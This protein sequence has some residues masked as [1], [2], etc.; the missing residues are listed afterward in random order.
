[1]EITALIITIVWIIWGTAKMKWHPFVV[2]LIAAFGLALALGEG[3][4]DAVSLINKGFGGTMSRIGLIILLGAMLGELLEK[5]GATEVIAFKMIKGLKKLP[6]TYAM[7]LI[8][9]VVAIPVFCDAAFILLSPLTKSMSKN[10]KV[11]GK[12]LTVALSTGLF[13]PHVLIPPTPGPLAAAATL[14]LNDLGLLIL[15]GSILALVLV[16]TGGWFAARMN[17][18]LQQVNPLEELPEQ[19]V[20]GSLA[21]AVLPII[22]PL[23]LI[24]GGTSLA[25]I[26]GWAAPWIKALSKPEV[27]LAIGVVVALGTAQRKVEQSS[28]ILNALRAGGPVLLITAMGGALGGVLKLIDVAGWLEGMVLPGAFVLVLPFTMAAVLKSAQGSSTVAIITTASM[29]LPLLAPF[30]LDTELGKVWVILSLGVGAMT[31]SHANDSYFWIVSEM[32]GLSSDEAFC[33]HTRATALQGIVGGLLVLVSGWI[34][35]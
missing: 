20:E 22:L 9:Y 19:E 27:A 23:L 12:A 26:E 30:G 5:G 33:Y 31:V 17:R 7:S 35:L 6:T 25:G 16:L 4:F 2:L 18:Q 32:G 1:M 13:A 24:A 21:R 28:W 15:A 29:M 10:A 34:V 11:S 8:G 3:A 14:G